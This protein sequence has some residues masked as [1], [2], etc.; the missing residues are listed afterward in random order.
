M[1]KKATY[2]MRILQVT[3]EAEPLKVGDWFWSLSYHGKIIGSGTGYNT[4]A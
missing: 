2:I 1:A 3:E 4:R